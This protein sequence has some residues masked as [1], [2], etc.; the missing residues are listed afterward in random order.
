MTYLLIIIIV[1]L[2]GA[3]LF[4]NIQ[5]YNQKK[6]FQIK[7]NEL[8]KIII[9]NN[10]KHALQQDQLHLSKE[11]E[12]RIKIINSTLSTTIFGLNFDLFNILSENDLLKK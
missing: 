2:V 6:T 10:K 1:L 7:L 8:H 11:L 12:D 9:E 3:I 4:L 5:I